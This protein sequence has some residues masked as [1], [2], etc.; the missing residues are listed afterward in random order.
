MFRVAFEGDTKEVVA[1][2]DFIRFCYTEDVRNK[3]VPTPTFRSL[4]SARNTRKSLN[5]CCSAKPIV[6][7][8]RLLRNT[9]SAKFS[10]NG[11]YGKPFISVHVVNLVKETIH[12][13]EFLDPATH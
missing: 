6:G 7:T 11:V 3:L 10:K 1:L 2:L 4:E 5:L 8:K 12:A 9:R 13:L